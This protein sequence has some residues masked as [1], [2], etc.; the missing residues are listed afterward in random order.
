MDADVCSKRLDVAISLATA[1]NLASAQNPD[2]SLPSLGNALPELIADIR[3]TP[4]NVSVRGSVVQSGAE[5]KTSSLVV[6]Y[7]IRDL[8]LCSPAL[9]FALAHPWGD[10]ESSLLYAPAVIY[11]YATVKAVAVR[12]DCAALGNL[13]EPLRRRGQSG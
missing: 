7:F 11:A 3:E 10:M 4:N 12:V 6:S 8:T 13:C 9:P 2:Q 5:P 1:A